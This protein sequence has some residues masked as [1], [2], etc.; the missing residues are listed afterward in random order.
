MGK[1]D[2]KD[3]AR[4]KAR[5]TREDFNVFSRL[6]AVYSASRKQ[7][8]QFLQMGGGL[9]IVEWRV[10]WDLHEGGPMT[11][12]DL[13]A[14]QRTD[15][16]LLSRALPAIRDKGYVTMR[17]DADDARQTIVEI[18]PMGEAAYAQA[19]PVMAARRAALRDV[20]TPDE[21]ETFVGFLDRLEEF[22]RQPV[23]ALIEKNP[24]E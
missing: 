5:R 6:P 11:I 9:S 17:R 21:I 1:P 22:L 23:E 7:G 14:L 16:S 18:A 24:A 4:I 8:Q 20:F 2:T 3:A 19:A 13:A 10:L 15:H 12:R